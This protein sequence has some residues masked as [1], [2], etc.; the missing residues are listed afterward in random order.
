MKKRTVKGFTLVELIV[1][2]AIIGVLAAILVPN[3]MGYVKKSRLSTAN[4]NAKIAYEAV[5]SYAADQ[6]TLGQA[7]NH[8]GGFSCV[9]SGIF[10]TVVVSATSGNS[11]EEVVKEALSDNGNGAGY[12]YC[13]VD[14]S[15]VDFVQWAKNADD[16]I[17]GQ[18]PNPPAALADDGTSGVSFGTKYTS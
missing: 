14:A 7:V 16:K 8:D 1:V 4:S 15:K 12:V 11:I 3:M 9:D 10:N 18:Y 13:K 2:I 17:I 6:E 5:S